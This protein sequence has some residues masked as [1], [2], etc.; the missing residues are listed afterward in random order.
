MNTEELRNLQKPI[1]DRYRE[2]PASALVKHTAKGTVQENI[3]FRVETHDGPVLAGLH[4][5][6]GGTGELAC[7]GDMLLQALVSCAGVTLGSVS[8]A[9][10]ITM[11]KG[12]VRAE[13]EIDYRGTMAV[14]K[15]VPTGFK[16]IRLI[17]D[18]DCDADPEKLQKLVQLTERYCIVY[19][20]IA[21][22]VPI[23]SEIA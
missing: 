9:M 15:E 20:T 17:F 12:T 1:K 14:S 18:L 8:T 5:A 6:T 4:P 2:D 11:R 16:S 21:A 19:Q 3:A 22:G 10:G 23:I 7:A 13:G